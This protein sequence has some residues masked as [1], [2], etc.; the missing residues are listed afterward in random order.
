MVLPGNLPFK[1][2]TLKYIFRFDLNCTESMVK[3][4]KIS[5][6]LKMFKILKCRH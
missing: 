6:L 2:V 4:I 5:G 3:I 1:T